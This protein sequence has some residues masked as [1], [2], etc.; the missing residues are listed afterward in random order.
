M[1]LSGSTISFPPRVDARGSIVTTDLSDDIVA[2]AI[3]DIIETRRG[4][5]V[6]MPDYGIPDFAFAV[7]NF[8]FAPRIAYILEQ[9][10]TNYVPLVRAVRVQAET[11]QYGRAIVSLRYQ[12][13]GNITAPR[14]MVFPLW[15]LVGGTA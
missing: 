8:S 6:M 4:E 13:V 3:A 11:D 14:N 1:N 5:R 7:Q 9:Q 15:Q 2:E 12:G 10:I